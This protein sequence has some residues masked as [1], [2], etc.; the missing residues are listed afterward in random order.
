MFVRLSQVLGAYVLVQL[1]DRVLVLVLRF[2][3]GSVD[4]RMRMLVR[5]GVRMDCAIR[6][7]VL[8]GVDVRVDM[9][10]SMLVLNLNCHEMFLL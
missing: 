1:V 10:V 6:M 2:L 7:L 4:M 9:R 8:M 5:V 3:A